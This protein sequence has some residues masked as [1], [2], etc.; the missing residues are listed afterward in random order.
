[1]ASNPTPD[2]YDELIA[3]GEDLCDGLNAHRVAI[4]IK[5]NT[6]AATRADLDALIADNNALSA[7][8]GAQPA[9]YTAQ[10]LADSNAKGFIAAAVKVVSISFGNAWSDA[11]QATGLPD[12]TA[13][14]PT[15]QDARF[16]AL[17]GLK[18]FFTAN[19]TM[20]V[21]TLMVTVTA[22]LA[23]TL[24]TAVRDAR[25]GV[26]N[27]L[28]DSKNKL[29]AKNDA[30]AAFRDRFR[31]T[32]DELGKLLAD[33]DPKWYDFGL[34]RPADPQA[35]GA[36]FH[37]HASAIGGGKI[38]VQLDG[39]RANSFNYYQQVVGTDADPVKVA[40]SGGTQWTLE[41][42]TVGATVTG[43]NDGGEGAAS[44]AV[45]VVVT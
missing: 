31:G 32:I 42:L 6:F 34:I 41:G 33:D 39:A 7:S 8:E 36:P 38:L 22:A 26:T 44:A 29:M 35:P 45:S 24:W 18:A 19:P 30:L 20:E 28:T 1:M 23:G 16:T 11:W 15:T 21:S 3:A 40:N 43:V 10:R 5:Q 4:G 27:G 37:V 12:N 2:R 17:N 9:K 25:L 14:V 13:G